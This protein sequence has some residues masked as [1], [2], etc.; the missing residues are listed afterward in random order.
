MIWAVVERPLDGYM[1]GDTGGDTV[2]LDRIMQTDM[3]RL[4]NHQ[5]CDEGKGR[6][7]WANRAQQRNKSNEK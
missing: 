4:R 3:G 2:G 5:V 1:G 7:N 6:L